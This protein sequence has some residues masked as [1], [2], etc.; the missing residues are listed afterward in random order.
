M[1]IIVYMEQLFSQIQALD[2]AG[3]QPEALYP[4]ALGALLALLVFY[5]LRFGRRKAKVT[6]GPIWAQVASRRRLPLATILSFLLQVIIFGALFSALTDPREKASP[7]IRQVVAVVIDTS[8]SMA[9][10]EGNKRRLD[11]AKEAAKPLVEKISGEDVGTILTAGEAPKVIAPLGSD[12]VSLSSSI[13]AIQADFG[14][15][16]LPAAVSLALRS[17]QGVQGGEVRRHLFIIS[18]DPAAASA[19][20]VP[21]EVNRHVINVGSNTKNAAVLALIAR[22]APVLEGGYDLLVK[23]RSFSK[24]PL[25]GAL[26]IATNTHTIGQVKLDLPPLSEVTKEYQLSESASLSE[27]TPLN[28]SLEIEGDALEI[29]NKIFTLLP[30]TKRAKVILVTTGNRFLEL[31]LKLNPEVS[32]EVVAP[33]AYKGAGGSNTLV[34]FDRIT[35]ESIPPKAILVEPQG[36]LSPFRIKKKII[37]PKLTEWNADSPILRNALAKDIHIEEASVFVPDRADMRL[38]GLPE[39]P[40]ALLREGEES[41][42]L[43]FGFDFTRSDLVLRI[44][45]PVMLR[46]ALLRAMGWG[47]AASKRSLETVYRVGQPFA[48]LPGAQLIGPDQK[49]LPR[50]ALGGQEVSLPKEPGVYQGNDEKGKVKQL[51]INLG[52]YEESDVSKVQPTDAAAAVS[53]LRGTLD[54]ESKE[55]RRPYWV[56]LI[57]AAIAV[58]LLD[59]MLYHGRIAY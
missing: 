33:E 25:R 12:G 55:P 7:T 18:D 47:D 52:A 42:L 6:A 56:Y 38:M 14:P 37:N 32:L 39:G 9:A 21:A 8:G 30:A 34:I 46:N 26:K 15:S 17:I 28:A 31:A 54:H 10:K 53:A 48:L 59:W 27:G 40:V 22:P 57:L 41:F 16:S 11:L 5:L 1:C 23:V 45:F 2:L 13:D 3:V 51:P 50:V 29:D 4:Y 36:N 35:P 58:A 19:L 44:A 43:A 20:Q 49:P 24:E